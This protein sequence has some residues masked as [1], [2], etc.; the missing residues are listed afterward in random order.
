LLAAVLLLASAGCEQA[1]PGAALPLLTTI[2]QVR[3]LRS[4]D[5]E[6]AYPVVLRGTVVY[7][8]AL[9]QFLV[10]QAGTDGV[11]VDTTKIPGTFTFGRQIEIEGRTGLDSVSPVVVATSA[12]D[13]GPGD[14]P[15]ALSLSPNDLKLRVNA[16]LWVEA[17]GT[18]RSAIAEIDGRLTLNIVAADGRFEAR[19]SATPVDGDAFVDARVRVRGVANTTFNVRG[20]PVRSR[21]LVPSLRQVE[22]LEPGAADPFSVSVQSIAALRTRPPGRDPG[23][24]V[25]LQGVVTAQPDGVQMVTDET[26]RVT[27]GVAAM[28][29]TLP[30]SRLD[31]VGYPA[32]SGA[33]LTLE[34]AVVRPIGEP[35][36][37]GQTETASQPA[38]G[39]SAPMPVITTVRDIRRLPPVEATRGLQVRLR[40]VVT[41]STPNNAFIQDSTAGIFVSTTDP[42]RSGQLVDVVGQTAAG[43][44]AP[45]ITGAHLHVIGRAALPTPVRVPINELFSGAYDSQWSEVEGIV[46][47]VDK[48][49][50]DASMFI[51]SGSYTF[52]VNLPGL[53]NQPL[54]T[55]LVDAKVRMAGACL[56][57]FNEKRQLL[58]ISLRVPGWDHVTVVEAAGADPRDLRVHAINTLMQF[59]PSS[60]AGHRVRLQGTAILQQANGSIYIKDATGGVVVRAS[61]TIAVVPGD[62][63]D[64]VGFAAKG[65]YLPELRSAVVL[66]TTRGVPAAPALVTTTEAMSGNYH[67]QLVQMEAYLLDQTQRGSERIL[68]LQ[69]GPR[70][71]TAS[72]E[73]TSSA[74]GLAAIRTGSLLQL[75]GVCLVDPD[76]NPAAGQRVR[77]QGFRLL[78]RSAADVVVLQRESWWSVARVLWLAGGLALVMVTAIG[79][80]VVLRRRVR[81]QTAIIRQQLEVEASLTEAAQS[82]NRA[83]SEFLANMSHEIRTPMSGVMG[84]TTLALDTELT[85]Y[86]RECLDTVNSSA[87]SL[88]TILNDILDFSKIESRKLEL[89][90]IPFTLADAIGDALKRLAVRAHQKGLELICDIDVGVPAGVVGDPGRLNQIVTNLVGNAVKFTETGHIVVAVREEK[91]EGDRTTLHVQVTDTGIGIAKEHQAGVFEAFKQADGTT[92]RR[93]GGTG[94]G[95]T[96]S[97]SL[98][99]LMGGR[100]W[101]ESEVGVGTTF[102]FTIELGVSDVVAALPDRHQLRELPVLIVDDNAV[103]RRVLA[104]QCVVWGMQPVCVEGGRAA[105]AAMTLAANSG[106]PFALMLLDVMMPEM[107]GF[108]VAAAVL[109]HPE[110]AVTKILI[111]SS[112]GLAGESDR[113]RALGIAA[114]LPKPVRAADLLTAIDRALDAHAPATTVVPTRGTAITTA[115]RRLRILVAEDNLV[116][117]RVA[118]GLLSK[119]GHEVVSVGNGREAFDALA[120]DH[121]FDV[122]L[123][124][125][126]MPEMDGLEATA[127]IRARERGTGSHVRIVAMTAHALAEDA[128][129]CLRA[130]MDGYL[131]KPLDVKILWATVEAPVETPPTIS[132]AA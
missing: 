21:V 117:Q 62:R 94:L 34:D 42:V 5:A 107:D 7:V 1:T 75:T 28:P 17:E 104:G 85:E 11:G 113:C 41:A 18:V 4:A 122:V 111:L 59:G 54:P 120:G 125:V 40:A 68:T 70:T 129:R 86:Q 105:L 71:F 64:V 67:A 123:M 109:Q 90:A 72:I 76:A 116:N 79:W 15:I 37:V 8:D 126:Q 20:Q 49:G 102:H 73:N 61:Q 119:R 25:H 32:A 92:T 29:D 97:V 80:V 50:A 108:E 118:R 60:G 58:G 46:Q 96:I 13:V 81:G 51:A 55:H 95:L 27:I 103:N 112:A 77:I 114:R 30:G 124:D 110:W 131:S 106:R 69:A 83:K 57:L 10:V 44:F 99:E 98:V 82:A 101:L 100:V 47:S 12:K 19:V 33:S 43:N 88:L 53:G 23:H 74:S 63:L 128:E 22:V 16:N 115:A 84:M 65:D 91:R 130:G 66:T 14:T 89:E 132:H 31:V 48:Q 39:A 87:T 2:A 3:A 6:R 36:S 45:I 52:R 38:P 127:A 121:Q 35:V 93:F 26:G 24:R 56:T 78:L 9:S